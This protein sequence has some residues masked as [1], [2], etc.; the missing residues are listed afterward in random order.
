MSDRL[1]TVFTSTIYPDLARLWHAC[2]SRSFPRH[3]AAIEVFQDSDEHEVSPRWLPGATV[4]RRAPS[5][6]DFHEAYNDALARVE[7]PYLAF[8]DTDVFWIAPDLWPR[9]RDV[10]LKDVLSAYFDRSDQAILRRAA[11]EGIDFTLPALR[12]ESWRRA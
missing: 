1:V 6:R 3:E 10:H 8:V 11:R 12:P 2:V 9:V 4:V 5:R 7:T